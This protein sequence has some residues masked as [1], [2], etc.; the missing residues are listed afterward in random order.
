MFYP[1]VP[2]TTRPFGAPRSLPT[3]LAFQL[4]YSCFRLWFALWI[5]SISDKQDDVSIISIIIIIIIIIMG[6]QWWATKHYRRWRKLHGLA[7]RPGEEEN[8]LRTPAQEI[9]MSTT[10]SSPNHHQTFT[11]SHGAASQSAF[12]RRQ[13]WWA[14]LVMYRCECFFKSNL[15]LADGSCGLVWNASCS[16]FKLQ[17]PKM[18]FSHFHTVNRS[19]VNRKLDGWDHA[20]VR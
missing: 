1:A 18:Q 17:L 3:L 13:D 5:G 4:I 19:K 9:N 6:S 7:C 11:I 20:R 10:A 16:L 14:R 15:V 12:C 8:H 2:G